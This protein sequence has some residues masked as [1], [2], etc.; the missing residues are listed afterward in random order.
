MK[1]GFLSTFNYFARQ[2]YFKQNIFFVA[3]GEERKDFSNIATSDRDIREQNIILNKLFRKKLVI[4]RCICK[5]SSEQLSA[6]KR[7]SL[8][9]LSLPSAM[10]NSCSQAVLSM[11]LSAD[12]WC[13]RSRGQWQM[14]S[15]IAVPIQDGLHGGMSPPATKTRVGLS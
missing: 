5:K 1:M 9:F 13:H 4:Y 3:G 12:Q 14:K 15:A 6:L 11:D 8:I 10:A 7:S 2:D